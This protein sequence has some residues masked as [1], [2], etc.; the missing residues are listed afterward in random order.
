MITISIT[1]V[2]LAA[3][4]ATM[5]EGFKAQGRADGKGNYLITL[6]R[7]VLDRWKVRPG[8]GESYSDVILR[9]AKGPK[10]VLSSALM[11]WWR[12]CLDH[13]CK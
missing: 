1:P 9:L 12:C 11:A 7:G 5:P 8:P 6:P 4:G 13:L 2:A 10:T 3:I